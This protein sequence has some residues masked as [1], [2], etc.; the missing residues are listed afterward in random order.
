MKKEKKELLTPSV[1]ETTEETVACVTAPKSPRKFNTRRFRYGSMSVVLTLVVAVA[2]VIT[3]VIGDL[4]N[5]RFPLNWDLTADDTYTFSETSEKVAALVDR[6][7]E[8]VVFM[9]ENAFKNPDYAGISGYT[10]PEQL[11]KVFRQFYEFTGRYHSLTDG[12]VTVRYI[13]AVNDPTAFAAYEK[14]GEELQQGSI[15]FVAGDRY[16]VSSIGSMYSLT[17]SIDYSTY[18]YVYTVAASNVEGMLSTNLQYLCR[19]EVVGVTILT[20]HG[21]Y[22]GAISGAT[23]V[24]SANGYDVHQVDFTTVTEIP[25][26]T[27]AL[28][29]AA[30]SKDYSVAEIERLRTWLNNG[31]KYN[32]HLFVLPHNTA[33]CPNLFEFLKEEYYIEFTDNMVAEDDTSK[34]FYYGNLY[35]I[36]TPAETDYTTGLT[37]GYIL[38]PGTRHMIPLKDSNTEYERYII[39]LGGFSENAKLYPIPRDEAASTE[40]VELTEPEQI[41][42]SVLMSV[43]DAYNNDLKMSVSTY[44]TVFGSKDFLTDGIRNGVSTAVNEQMFVNVANTVLGNETAISVP[45]RELTATTLEF[46]AKT[47]LWLGLGVFVIIVPLSMI[48]LAFVVFFRRRHL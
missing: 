33:E 5:E 22:D 3:C 37:M 12:K 35:T 45:T 38:T 44:V 26:N 41:P 6:D 2:L 32:R 48:V 8:I 20:G 1:A 11:N 39:S 18:S 29:I 46:N 47:I 23:Q 24:L 30:P 31:D 7:V 43:F 10:N 9:E 13:D 28:L 34:Q 19:K 14:Y 17:Q 40:K 21:E 42:A 4:L 27:K 16:R 36:A 25:A 15:L